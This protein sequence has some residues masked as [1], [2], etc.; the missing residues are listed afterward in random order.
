MDQ[1]SALLLE[2][3]TIK[4]GV[5]TYRAINHSLRQKML[6]MVHASGRMTVTSIYKELNMEQSLASQHLAILRKYGF[7]T[8]EREGK[9]VFYKV[10][11]ARLDAIHQ[12]TRMIV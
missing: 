1:H 5:A 3:Q 2:E 4:K 6:R 11:Y 9:F 10:N 7:M 12:M 8:T